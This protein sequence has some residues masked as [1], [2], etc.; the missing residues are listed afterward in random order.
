MLLGI[1]VPCLYQFRLCRITF[2]QAVSGQECLQRSQRHNDARMA[3][4]HAQSGWNNGQWRR[5]MFSDGS[6][7]YL[8]RVDG[9]KRVW[10]RHRAGHVPATVIL[11]VAFQGGWS[12]GVERDLSNCEDQT[13]VFIEENLNGQGLHKKFLRHTCCHFCNGCQ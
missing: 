9:R 8:K 12:H 7:F 6:R 13:L 4:S 10:R 11:T 1:G 2:I 3:I 5:V